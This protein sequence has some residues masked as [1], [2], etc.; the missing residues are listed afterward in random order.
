[1]RSTQGMFDLIQ[2]LR[3]ETHHNL[4]IITVEQCRSLKRTYAICTRRSEFKSLA[5]D[6]LGW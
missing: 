6:Y 2:E 1:M 4:D 5:K 3:E